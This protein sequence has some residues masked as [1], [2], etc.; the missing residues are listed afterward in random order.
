MAYGRI[1]TEMGR[2]NG[3]SRWCHRE[4]AKRHANKRRR[5]LDKASTCE[6]AVEKGP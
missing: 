4:D 3:K 2:R 5:R 6:G 1:K